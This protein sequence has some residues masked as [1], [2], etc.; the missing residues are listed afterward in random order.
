MAIPSIS[1]VVEWVRSSFYGI[2]T[3]CGLGM[4]WNVGHGCSNLRILYKE[5]I[6]VGLDK[7]PFMY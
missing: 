1:L 3:A 2:P 5:A 7:S 6:T 4:T